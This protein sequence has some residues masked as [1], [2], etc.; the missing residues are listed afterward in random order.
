MLSGDVNELSNDID[1]QESHFQGTTS[2]IAPAM[3]AAV[4]ILSSQSP[5]GRNKMVIVITD[6]VTD[7]ASLSNQNTRLTNIGASIFGIYTL[8]VTSSTNTPPAAG[9]Q[10]MQILSSPSNNFYYQ[11]TIADIHNVLNGLCNPNTQFGE[12]L[13]TSAPPIVAPQPCN[14]ITE[15]LGCMRNALCEWRSARICTYTN[16]CP[17][18][19]CRAPLSYYTTSIVNKRTVNTYTTYKCEQCQ[20]LSDNS[21]SCNANTNNPVVYTRYL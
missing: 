13:G 6:G 7:Y 4:N 10:L 8:Q 11:S 12:A 15:K 21:I 20:L 16:Y 9:T 18:L 17:N 1:W 19:D 2:Y 14:L 3:T 5:A